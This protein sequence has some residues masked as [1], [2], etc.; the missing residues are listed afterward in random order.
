MLIKNVGRYVVPFA[1][2]KS[3]TTFFLYTPHTHTRHAHRCSRA[4]RNGREHTNE[5]TVKKFAALVGS[6]LSSPSMCATASG[7]F[8]FQLL[9]SLRSRLLGSGRAAGR[10]TSRTSSPLSAACRRPWPLSGYSCS[11]VC[12]CMCVCVV[13]AVVVLCVRLYRVA[14]GAWCVVRGAWCVEK[15]VSLADILAA[16][17]GVTGPVARAKASRSVPVR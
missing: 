3:S 17:S 4:C 14:R 9:G 12:G 1:Q 8:A 15:Q 11:P 6:A 10:R 16:G 7:R 2:E 13:G 5:L